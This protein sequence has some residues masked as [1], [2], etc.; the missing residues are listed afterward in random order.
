MTPTEEAQYEYRRW[1][2]IRKSR[3]YGCG[4]VTEYWH[5]MADIALVLCVVVVLAQKADGWGSDQVLNLGMII[6]TTQLLFYVG[7]VIF[8]TVWDWWKEKPEKSREEF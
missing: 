6:A 8:W 1:E 4:G 3:R 2:A 7:A 5:K